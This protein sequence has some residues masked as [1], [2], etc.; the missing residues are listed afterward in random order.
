MVLRPAITAGLKTTPSQAQGPLRMYPS[1]RENTGTST[2]PGQARDRLSPY[3][4]AAGYKPYEGERDN[5][6]ERDFGELPQRPLQC[7]PD[8][9]TD[10][11]FCKGWGA[12]IPP[13]CMGQAR[14]GN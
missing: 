10:V 2:S 8:N 14:A 6:G 7:I 13:W 11:L 9:R 5:C 3:P 1:L 12:K 4:G